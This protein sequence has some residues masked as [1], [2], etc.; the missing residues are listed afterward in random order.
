MAR[1]NHIRRWPLLCLCCLVSLAACSPAGPGLTDGS[2]KTT[3]A[4][5]AASSS[6]FAAGAPAFGVLP[7]VPPE[8]QSRLDPYKSSR[9]YL[10]LD[11]DN[12]LV[13]F[14]GQRSTGGYS[15]ELLSIQ[16]A[17][18]ALV[19]RILEKSPKPG[20]PVTQALTYPLL[21]LRL[22]ER[23]PSFQI[24]DSNGTPYRELTGVSY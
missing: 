18:Q 15:M 11:Q 16:P 17:G 7:T 23:F 12:L 10:Y 13:I 9:G 22:E 6:S 8:L 21:I 14:M 20:D 1:K 24:F 2:A 5:S 4:N 19:I 3:T